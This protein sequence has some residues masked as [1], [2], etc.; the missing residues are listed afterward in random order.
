MAKLIRKIDIF[1]LLLYVE[2]VMN[3]VL[4]IVVTPCIDEKEYLIK[5]PNMV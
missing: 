3:S 2:P 4:H 1:V 5:S